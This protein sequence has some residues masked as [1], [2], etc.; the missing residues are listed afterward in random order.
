MYW[1]G[2]VYLTLASAALAAARAV[3]AASGKGYRE[4]GKWSPLYGV[5]VLLSFLA[6][7][8]ALLE[9]VRVEALY[10]LV[11]MAVFL[12][13]TLLRPRVSPLAVLAA[14]LG[15]YSVGAASLR[16]PPVW[17]DADPRLEPGLWLALGLFFAAGGLA[18]AGLASEPGRRLPGALGG[19]LAALGLVVL[20]WLF[21]SSTRVAAMLYG[22]PLSL[23]L[24][25]LL[26]GLLYGAWRGSQLGYAAGLLGFVA[27]AARLGS[28]GFLKA[29]G[30]SN[31]GYWVGVYLLLVA[32]PRLY[33]EASRGW[34]AVAPV[35]PGAAAAALSAIAAWAAAEPYGSLVP[36]Y[37]AAAA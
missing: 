18:A 5:P 35:L 19:P 32:A 31:V 33:E 14:A 26:V 22:D 3:M 23:G 30:M 34:D 11:F 37:A 10:P 15:A 9:P 29:Y 1:E 6:L 12:A 13:A 21:L 16:L 27:A 2:M 25:A 7:V 36:V 20:G 8:A 17:P 4:P 24:F 28:M